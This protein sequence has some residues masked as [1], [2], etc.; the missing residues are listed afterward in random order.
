MKAVRQFVYL[1]EYKM[2]SL[3]SQMFEGFTEYVVRYDEEG[4]QAAESQKGPIASGRVLA[5]I[6]ASKRG[7]EER[8]FLHD[9]AYTVFEDELSRRKML[10]T[11][12]GSGDMTSELQPGRVVKIS[13][14][15]V[16]NDMQAISKL[17][18]RFNDFGLAI[19]YVTTLKEREAAIEQ[20][21]AAGK[22]Q[23][24]RNARAKLR[25]A[26]KAVTDIKKL[27]DPI[28]LYREIDTG[29]AE[30]PS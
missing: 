1:D 24:D 28:A 6:V 9:Y 27:V 20:A 22:N 29:G 30:L 19:T 25:E 5:D 16:F 13:G 26:A 4:K 17:I 18:E 23:G 7:Q 8:R 11:I 10:T 3:Y 2:Y 14:S 12:S 21:E 15:A